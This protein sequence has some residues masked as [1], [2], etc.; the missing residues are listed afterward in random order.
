[1]AQATLSRAIAGP[2]LFAAQMRKCN[3]VEMLDELSMANAI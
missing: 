1:M 3:Q 2:S